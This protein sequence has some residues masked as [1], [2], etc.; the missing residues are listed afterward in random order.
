MLVY[1][2]L[3]SFWAFALAKI[4]KLIQDERI[5][6]NNTNLSEQQWSMY[7]RLHLYY[8]WTSLKA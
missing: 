2:T 5:I 7:S 8:S 1:D 3:L 4:Q 6:H